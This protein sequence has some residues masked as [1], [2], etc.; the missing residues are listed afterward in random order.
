MAL[1]YLRQNTEQIRERIRLAAEAAGREAREIDLLAAVKYA[2][3]EEIRFLY[4]ELGIRDLGENRV[5]Q[6][7]E[8]YETLGWAERSDLRLH[9]IGTLQTNKVK[10]IIDKV[11]LIHSVDSL[12]LAAEIDRQAKKHGLVM[13]ILAEINCGEEP[14]KSGLMPADVEDFCLGLEQFS[15]IRLRGFMT[16]APKCD[17]KADYLKYFQQT[18][19][20]VLDIWTKKLHNIDRPLISMGMSESF[21]EAIACGSDIV[22]IGRSLFVKPDLAAGEAQQM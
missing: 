22:R 6:L 17:Q 3:P 7:L 10:Y 1:E 20:Q 5:Q 15:G 13:D 16:M 18:Y 12:K 21:E 8:H 4:E 14:G 9:F 19:A 11:A 2:T